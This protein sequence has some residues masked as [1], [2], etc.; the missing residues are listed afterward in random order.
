M[1]MTNTTKPLEVVGT[2]HEDVVGELLI[3]NIHQLW[4]DGW[5]MKAWKAEQKGAEACVCCGKAVK[6]GNGSRI[7]II[8][9]D[10]LAPVASYDEMS[11]YEGDWVAGDLGS[12]PIGPDCAKK[13]PKEYRVPNP[14]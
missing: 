10:A 2:R 1:V 3:V 14:A 8:Y 4:A 12:L 6:P 7:W 5:E 9:G 13:I 11:K